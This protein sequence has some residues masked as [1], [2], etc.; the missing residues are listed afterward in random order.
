M[1]EDPLLKRF[2]GRTL[3]IATKHRK[4]K[5]IAPLL[6]EALGVTCQVNPQLDTDRFGTFSGE[7][8]R[9][10]DPLTTLRKKCL[11]A[12]DVSGGDLVLGNEGSFGPHPTIGLIPANEEWMLLIDRKDPL[13]VWVRSLR[14]ETN[15]SA[16]KANTESELLAFAQQVKFPGH[17]LILRPFADQALDVHKGI[18]DP[19]HLLQT[20][21]SLRNRYG[22][23]QV[24]TDMRALYNPTRMEGIGALT[25]K[26]IRSLRSACP[27]CQ[28][29]GFD[30]VE[31]IPGLPCGQCGSETRSTLRHRYQCRACGQEEQRNFPNGKKQEDPMYCDFCNP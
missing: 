15:F 12:L 8:E 5:V 3:L 26:L 1:R 17:G 2:G 18:T 13:E 21:R 28:T 10:E 22:S 4:E 23:V 19:E 7:I 9:Q 24:E 11:Y 6:E 20:Y 30:V 27:A 14:T 25:E 29:P 31:A 16:T